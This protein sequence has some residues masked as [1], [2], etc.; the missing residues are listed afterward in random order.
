M[1][2]LFVALL[3]AVPPVET[4]LAPLMGNW[5][6][7]GTGAPGAGTGGFSFEPGLQSKVVIRKNFAE[8]PK[9]ADRP[10]F[11]HDDLTVIYQEGPQSPIRA[12]YYDNEGHVI[13]YTVTAEGKTIRF[14]GDVTAG[15]P[16]FRLTY[17]VTGTD[18]VRIQFDMAPPGK[19][20]AFTPYIDASARRTH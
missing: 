20:E 14:L 10:A 16:R 5:V 1:V 11:R 9:T 13:R 3:L 19:P 17:T 18:T 12:D 15:A 2:S 7:E 6:G 4:T 8:Y